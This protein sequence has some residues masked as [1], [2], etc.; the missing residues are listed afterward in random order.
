MTDPRSTDS[1]AH[2]LCR[3]KTGAQARNSGKAS[4]SEEGNGAAQAAPIAL[5]LAI[6]TLLGLGFFYKGQ[7]REFLD[8]F[9]HTV[10]SYGPAGW[11]GSSTSYEQG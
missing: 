3:H 4:E 1:A 6:A 10:D 8:Y 2:G 5:A 9:I 7:I 11:V